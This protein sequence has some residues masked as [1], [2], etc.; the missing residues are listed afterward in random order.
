[1]EKFEK[2]LVK[3]EAERR[4][5]KPQ[6]SFEEVE[7]LVH[8]KL[9]DDYRKFV[10]NY[11]WFGNFIREQYVVLFDFDEIIEINRDYGVF[12]Y[13]SKTLVIGGNGSGELIALEQLND[14]RLR[15]VLTPWLV[16]EE[17][18][19]EIGNSFTDMLERLDNGQ[20]WFEESR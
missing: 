16:E 20:E 3:Y 17:G 14:N 6:T 15:V 12:Q 9:P 5:D 8:L 11:M 10:L 2:I 4:T 1:M 13:L 19:I 7:K 18:H